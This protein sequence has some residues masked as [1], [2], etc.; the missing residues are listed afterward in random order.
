MWA[1]NMG[2]RKAAF[3]LIEL[4]VVIAIIAILAAILFPVFAAAKTAAKKTMSLSNVKQIGMASQ[5]YM[6]DYDDTTPP[7]FWFDPLALD[8]PTAQGFHYYALLMLPYTINEKI[9]LCPADSAEDPVLT[10]PQG[11]GR[12]DASSSYRYY[13]M[14]ANPSY[15]YNYRYLNRFLG[16]VT[17][18]GMPTRQFSGV[19]MT[20]IDNSA[21]TVMFAEATMKGLRGVRNSVGY[22]LIEPPFGIA[23]V[24]YAGWTGSYPD[25]RSQGQLWGRFDKKSVLVAWL[26]GHAKVA[27]IASLKAD[28]STEDDVNRMWNGRG[29]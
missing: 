24:G 23:S 10:D 20:S 22:A 13:F 28:G 18:M 3:T 9:F 6:G 19:A 14:G 7:V 25:A 26:D 11:K 29:R 17:I 5:L 4:L 27:Q 15:G 21:E 1:D 16:T 2:V 12:F 8:Y